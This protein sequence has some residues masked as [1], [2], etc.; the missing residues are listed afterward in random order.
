MS[1]GELVLCTPRTQLPS[2]WLPRQGSIPLTDTALSATLAGLPPVWLPRRIAE[3][4][5]THKQWIPYGLLERADGRL[6]SY[7]RQGTEARLHGLRSLGIG[8]HVNPGDAPAPF[9]WLSTLQ[10][11]FARELAEE[12]PAATTGTT[13]M[14]G[15]INEDTSAVGLVHLGLVFHHRLQHFPAP[16][17]GELA[18]LEWLLPSELGSHAHEAW[19]TLALQILSAPARP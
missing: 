18:G 15:L 10:H 6:A 4:D 13:R 11:G 1:A 19:S 17:A 14:L 12:Y 5:P 7:P 2:G 3:T 9:D 8:G 16:P